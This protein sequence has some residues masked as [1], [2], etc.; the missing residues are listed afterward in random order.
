M[1]QISVPNDLRQTK[2]KG[3][4]QMGLLAAWV[5]SWMRLG[6]LGGTA[7]GRGNGRL[8]LCV[9]ILLGMRLKCLHDT[10]VA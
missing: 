3:S 1:S 9:H 7:R 5:D 6:C 2:Q 4:K 8:P 10:A